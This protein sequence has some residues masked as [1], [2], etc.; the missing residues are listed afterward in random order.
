MTTLRTIFRYEITDREGTIGPL[1]RGWTVRH[2]GV[3]E[4]RPNIWIEVPHED[5]DEAQK[6]FEYK[7]VGTGDVFPSNWSYLGTWV[8]ETGYVWHLYGVPGS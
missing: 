4:G 7:V 6:Q 1:R 8:T 2:V 3:K 5:D